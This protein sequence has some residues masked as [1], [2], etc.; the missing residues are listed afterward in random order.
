MYKRQG[1]AVTAAIM[2]CSTVL[3]GC[4]GKVTAQSLLLGAASKTASESSYDA[5]LALDLEA[6]GTVSGVSV[7][8]GFYVDMDLSL[9]HI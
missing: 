2:L 9:I 8:M 4:R 3:A 5:N 7:D 6:S 1:Y